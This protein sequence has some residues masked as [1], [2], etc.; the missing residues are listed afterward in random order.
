MILLLL[1]EKIITIEKLCLPQI[2]L[3]VDLANIR[4]SIL[5]MINPDIRE[6]VSNRGLSITLSSLVGYDSEYELNSSSKMVND[7][8]S[9]Q[10]AGSTG[11]V[12]KIPVVSKYSKKDLNIGFKLRSFNKDEVKLGNIFHNSISEVVD[13]IRRILYENN[14]KLLRDLI[15]VLD[16]KRVKKVITDSYLVYTFDKSNVSSKYIDIDGT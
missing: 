1:L 11:A 6:R 13:N 16:N 10:L 14:D 2:D 7:L 12:L 15:D 3:K 4:K 9:I 8:L 5:R